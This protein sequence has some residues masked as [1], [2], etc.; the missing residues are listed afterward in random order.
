MNRT[1]KRKR[2]KVPTRLAFCLVMRS[3]CWRVCRCCEPRRRNQRQ[4]FY[5]QFWPFPTSYSPIA[6]RSLVYLGWFFTAA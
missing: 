6:L 5:F 2:T 4:R 3:M 1:A